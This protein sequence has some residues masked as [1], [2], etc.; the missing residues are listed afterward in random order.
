ME[1][2]KKTIQSWVVLSMVLLIS[3]M[4]EILDVVSCWFPRAIPRL[5]TIAG[6]GFY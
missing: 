2:V 3:T 4:L 1:S 6:L 5:M